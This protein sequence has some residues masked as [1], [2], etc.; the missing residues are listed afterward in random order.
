MKTCYDANMENF[1]TLSVTPSLGPWEQTRALDP[2]LRSE[3][4]GGYVS[5]RP[6]FTRIPKKW[7]IAYQ[8]GN[9]LPSADKTTL[10]A[11]EETVKVGSDMFSWVNPFDSQT[12]T[13]RLAG[14]IVF[15]PIVGSL[16][17]EASFELE[18]V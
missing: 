10:E 1:P 12:Y 2:T 18:E 4:E 16:R 17:W 11:F 9:S 7:K 3:K 6:R 15:K 13:V 8:Q 5:T 14:P